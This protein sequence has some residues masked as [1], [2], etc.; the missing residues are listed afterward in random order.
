MEVGSNGAE[1]SPIL[2]RRESL[3]IDTDRP[4]LS[5]ECLPAALPAQPTAATA[6]SAAEPLRHEPQSEWDKLRNQPKHVPYRQHGDGLLEAGLLQAHIRAPL[7][8]DQLEWPDVDG[9]M[10]NGMPAPRMN[11]PPGERVGIEPL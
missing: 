10:L 11:Q 1:T 9:V 7:W 4:I 3:K 5:Q 2:S 6:P 8:N